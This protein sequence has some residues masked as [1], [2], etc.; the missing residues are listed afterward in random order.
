M[1]ISRTP[2]RV[3]LF[4]G[5]TDYSG[6]YREHG[7]AVLATTID[8]FCYI[9]VPRAPAL[10]RPPIPRRLLRVENV[11]EV[12]E[13]KASGRPRRPRH[14]ETTKGLEIHHD[15]DLPARAG[16][17][18]S[19]AFTVRPVECAQR[20]SGQLHLQRSARQRSDSRRAVRAEGTRRPA[21][22]DSGRLRR[23]Q[24]IEFRQDGSFTV[25]PMILPRQRQNELQDHLMLYFTGISR[26]APEVAQTVIDNL[27]RATDSCTMRRWWTK[28]SP[29]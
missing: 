7:G 19:S 12:A 16:L 18:S 23:L 8:K 13:I 21:G 27:Q 11:R 2:F 15:G 1:I 14:T 28:R 25:T 22:S 29:S 17:G 26:L 20:P 4:G 6:W 3:S 9:S 24:Q 5:G 10:L